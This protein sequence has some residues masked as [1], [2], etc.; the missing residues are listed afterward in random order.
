MNPLWF[1]RLARWARHPPS[2]KKVMLI[3]AVL[4]LCLLAVGVEKYVGWPEWLTV[5]GKIGRLPK[6]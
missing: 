4:A 1:L 3:G 2:L 6:P 5:N